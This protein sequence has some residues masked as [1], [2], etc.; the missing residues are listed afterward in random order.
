MKLEQDDPVLRDKRQIVFG[1]RRRHFVPTPMM[2][3]E[4]ANVM[5][6]LAFSVAGVAK[7]FFLLLVRRKIYYVLT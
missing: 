4:Q 2:I 5:E 6:Y 3:C 1:R 7:Q